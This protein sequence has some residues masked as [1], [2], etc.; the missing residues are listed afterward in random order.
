LGL[1]TFVV[2][3]IQIKEKFLGFVILGEYIRNAEIKGAKGIVDILS[4]QLAQA[5][6]NI[7]L[8]EQLYQA[9]KDLQYKIKER[10][11]DLEK[12]L[13]KVKKASNLKTEFVSAVS[14]EFRTPLTSIKGYASLLIQNK[15]GKLPEPIKI[16]LERI[17]QQ[18]DNLVGMINDLLDISRIESGRLRINVEEIDITGLIKSVN[19]YL[20]P[21][22]EK[23][24]IQLSTSLDPELK[25]KADEQLIQRA[26]I[27]ILSNAVKFTQEGK[28]ITVYAR[29]KGDFVEISVKDQGPGISPED[30]D[31]IFK[32]FYRTDDATGIEGSGL[33][34][35]LVRNIVRMHQ[36]RVSVESVLGKGSIFNLCFPKKIQ[37]LKNN[38]E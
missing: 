9:Q 11:K 18:A 29:D 24:N 34:L 27:N 13:E 22:L 12:A 20:F 32:E 2:S 31:N 35:S 23:K 16:R 28:K 33:G 3:A 38:K 7:N 6:E 8:F 21:Q 19:D 5:L 36:G 15:F 10:T 4:T 14:H 25:I 30:K 17:N 37:P 1:N 26:L